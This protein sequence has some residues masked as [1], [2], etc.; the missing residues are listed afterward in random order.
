M[1]FISCYFQ[2]FLILCLIQFRNCNDLNSLITSTIRENNF[3]KK[4]AFYVMNFLKTKLL[5]KAKT[6]TS[7]TKLLELCSQMTL[8]FRTKAHSALHESTG[9]KFRYC[10][11][12]AHKHICERNCYRD[13]MM[14]RRCD[15]ACKK[16]DADSKTC[17]GYHYIQTC[18]FGQFC[19]HHSPYCC[20]GK[21]APCLNVLHT[22]YKKLNKF[23]N[24]RYARHLYSTKSIIPQKHYVP[25]INSC[26][27]QCG[28]KSCE[29]NCV[30][31]S[32]LKEQCINR[33]SIGN[34]LGKMIISKYYI[35]KNILSAHWCYTFSLHK[36]FRLNITFMKISLP[37]R[38]QFPSHKHDV[39]MI[40]RSSVLTHV[41]C[42]NSSCE[43][44][45]IMKNK[46]KFFGNHSSFPWFS[47]SKDIEI[48]L[49]GKLG[50]AFVEQIFQVVSSGLIQNENSHMLFNF[51]LLLIHKFIE[52]KIYFKSFSVK[53][54]KT[55][56]VCLSSS[57]NTTQVM[58][59]F[60]GPRPLHALKFDKIFPVFC[61][62]SF[63]ILLITKVRSNTS[64]YNISYTGERMTGMRVLFSPNNKTGIHLE[65][66]CHAGNYH[67]LV[68]V[69]GPQ[70]F[71]I[72][73]SISNYKQ[74]GDKSLLC[75]YGGIAI[76]DS[77]T[78][79]SFHLETICERFPG[80]VQPENQ[81]YFSIHFSVMIVMFRFT[82]VR[83]V[84]CKVI[85]T[86]SQCHTVQLSPCRHAPAHQLRKFVGALSK[87]MYVLNLTT[88]GEGQ[89]CFQVQVGRESGHCHSDERISLWLAFVD[90]FSF[91]G[92]VHV[93]TAGY[94]HFFH[95][96]DKELISIASQGPATYKRISGGIFKTVLRGAWKS[97][98]YNLS[99][100]G[101]IP[102]KS[103]VIYE[104]HSET[105]VQYKYRN[106]KPTW[107]LYGYV[108]NVWH[109]K[110]NLSQDI[111]GA[112]VIYVFNDWSNLFDYL[113][114][115]TRK[116]TILLLR[117]VA[118]FE[119]DDS[120]PT[121][122]VCLQALF[123]SLVHFYNI[124]RYSRAIVSAREILDTKHPLS[125]P[126]HGGRISHLRIKLN[127]K[128]DT[129]NRNHLHVN[130]MGSPSQG[131]WQS[132]KIPSHFYIKA[133]QFAKPPYQ[134]HRH[135]FTVN[136]T[137]GLYTSTRYIN[138]DCFPKHVGKAGYNEGKLCSTDKYFSWIE[139][140]K[141]CA[142]IWGGKLPYFYS[143]ARQE[144]LLEILH[145]HSPIPIE[146]FFIG[147]KRNN[148]G[149]AS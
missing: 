111:R 94:S 103:T 145:T 115:R 79:N 96:Y 61:A 84:N 69:R 28:K 74:H 135:G 67:C 47:D 38:K 140:H 107:H 1:N 133:I 26:K 91:Q 149:Q 43:M 42:Y 143:K 23:Q 109:V 83:A 147:L 45:R 70:M 18:E 72:G 136:S 20:S 82:G 138:P 137:L 87:N 27:N 52:Q 113:K 99:T 65:Q 36:E 51:Q 53:T 117:K 131:P 46:G 16:W 108:W 6:R 5:Q 95:G 35:K 146:A 73:I 123:E 126:F 114:K 127:E 85:P 58:Q 64:K 30:Y 15:L 41:N 54:N 3:D 106:Y 121:V 105:R 40:G 110:F 77:S 142:N 112:G 49:T 14:G 102:N 7:A 80:M 48:F 31:R 104:L 93:T 17:V 19:A 130:W 122:A 120:Y 4:W 55:R 139:A 37:I 97:E 29:T 50:F 59:L 57:R 148:A 92:T 32:P 68:N 2:P 141:Y 75:E 60:V 12:C 24:M 132:I 144:E 10:N 11:T 44:E 98:A 34:I 66:V 116:P 125:F 88:V 134:L 89:T 129:K 90:L 39:L 56:Q 128:E 62:K 21:K 25:I 118:R 81:V 76:F 8:S 22:A 78:D 33:F 124:Y 9:G 13:T 100:T 119:K 71:K 86:F 101:V 63:H